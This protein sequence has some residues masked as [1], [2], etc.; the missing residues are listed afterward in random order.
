MEE[1]FIVDKLDS[2][3]NLPEIV[4]VKANDRHPDR[5]YTPQ[6]IRYKMQ[7]GAAFYLDGHYEDGVYTPPQS[8][9]F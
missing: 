3:G 2:N 5:Y 7:D 1:Y 4:Q 8:F 6:Q 9:S